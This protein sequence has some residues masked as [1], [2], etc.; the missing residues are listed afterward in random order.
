MRIPATAP[1]QRKPWGPRAKGPPKLAKPN[2]P[3]FRTRRQDETLHDFG[4]AILKR[5]SSRRVN[6]FQLFEL[7]PSLLVDERLVE[8]MQTPQDVQ[9][10]LPTLEDWGKNSIFRFRSADNPK[11]DQPWYEVGI[12]VSERNRMFRSAETYRDWAIY[13]NAGRHVAEQSRVDL[14]N[15]DTSD[16]KTAADAGI[17]LALTVMRGILDRPTEYRLAHG[18]RTARERISNMPAVVTISLSKP[19]VQ[20][21]GAGM[22]GGWKMPE[23]DVRGHE[24][25]YK[26]GKVVWVEGHK[27]G[28]KNV[29][30]KTTYK[31]V[32]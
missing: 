26:S 18:A 10:F 14:L 4:Q 3:H 24:R 32:P 19:I 31:V 6:A 11:P 23:H 1:N 16:I 21:L 7:D 9:R 2:A 13:S 20:T 25:R 8:L 15:Y 17:W 5:C 29:I 30:R 22:G 12:V 27:R 28:D